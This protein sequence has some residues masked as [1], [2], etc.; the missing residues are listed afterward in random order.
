[1]CCPLF[2]DWGVQAVVSWVLKQA[3]PGENISMIAE[4]DTKGLTGE[5]GVT[6]L[7]P[8]V[9]AVNECLAE[10]HLVG[11]DP[12]SAPLTAVDVLRE[13]STG[14]S[15]GGSTGRHWILDPV[16]GTLG[17]VRADQYAI[18]LALL[19][20]GKLTVGALG[21][22]NFPTRAEWLKYPHRFHRM[23]AKMY[24]GKWWAKGFILKAQK[25]KGTHMVQLVG[26]DGSLEEAMAVRV[27]PVKDPSMVTFCEPVEKANSNQAFTQQLSEMLNMR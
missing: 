10:A 26:D 9:A 25:D 16:D 11:L 15:E 21:C 18:A 22:P 24:K 4:E 23:V 13:I 6:V 1:M 14:N 12:P 19:D 8:L 7:Q 20:S 3:Y 17:F 2:T 27:S 5:A